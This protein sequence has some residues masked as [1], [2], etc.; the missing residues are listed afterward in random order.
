MC[1]TGHAYALLSPDEMRWNPR[2]ATLPSGHR[3]WHRALGHR[4]VR[5][6]GAPHFGI[7][8]EDTVIQAHGMGPWQTTYVNQA[9][10]PA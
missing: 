1:A 5:P 4:V 2:R 8:D 9:K 6:G 7:V 10:S 3:A